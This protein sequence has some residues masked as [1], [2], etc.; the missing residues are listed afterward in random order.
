MGLA[1]AQ[2]VPVVML[3]TFSGS[4]GANPNA[5]LLSVSSGD[6]GGATSGGG[7]WSWGTIFR[8]SRT[9]TFAS[10]YSF[11]GLGERRTASATGARCGR[12]GVRH[13]R[14][15]VTDEAI[16]D[17][18]EDVLSYR[19]VGRLNDSVCVFSANRR[20]LSERPCRRHRGV[21]LWRHTRWG[22]GRFWH[23]IPPRHT[24]ALTVLYV[25]TGTGEQ[26]FTPFVQ[27]YDGNLYGVAQ[28]GVERMTLRGEISL[29][30]F[31][32]A[33]DFRARPQNGCG[34]YDLDFQAA[35]L[36][37]FGTFIVTWGGSGTRSFA[38]H[39]WASTLIRRRIPYS[40]QSCG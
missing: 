19:A 28:L 26:I 40:R 29:L 24:R 10:L 17:P 7:L 8:I 20:L 32:P 4:D 23:R 2:P 6:V 12:R 14:R 22:C 25:F 31:S 35:D 9:G 30:A 33:G 5:P 38:S 36:S 37:I 21:L 39:R 13:D 1:S 27:G 3:H 16:P 15:S 34:S 11:L 18:W